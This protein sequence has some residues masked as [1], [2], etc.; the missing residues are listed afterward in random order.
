MKKGLLALLISIIF[1]STSFSQTQG[2][3]PLTGNS[4]FLAGVELRVG[5]PKE[6]ILAKVSKY[7]ELIHVPS[8]ST[9]KKE[10]A[11]ILTDKNSN[12]PETMG[13]ILFI[14]DKLFNASKNWKSVYGKDAYDLLTSL[15]HLFS[16]LKKE[17]L[18]KPIIQLS[19]DYD[20]QLK[21]K[22][23]DFIFGVKKVEIIIYDRNDSYQVTIQERISEK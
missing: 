18:D 17:G 12:H 23:V 8:E 21:V 20:P 7:Y 13:A 11:Y 16:Q 4:L 9:S 2:F 5:M 22:H 19:E 10:E 1:N 15:F 14:N 3:D 6:P